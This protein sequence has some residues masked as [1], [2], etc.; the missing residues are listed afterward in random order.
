MPGSTRYPGTAEEYGIVLD[1]YNTVLNELFAGQEVYLITCDWSDGP[2]PGVRPDDHTR[3]HPGARYWTSVC[4]DP[5]ETDPDFISYTHLFVSRI[6]WQ[7]GALDEL[8]R[9]V[10]DD[11][12]AGVMITDLTMERI[13]HPYDGGADV[14]L[15]TTAERDELGHRY[16]DWLSPHPEGL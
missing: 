3:W 4:N 1:R 6:P 15:P 10:A 2:E 13:H 5:T 12:T 14:L 7:P 9:A 16:A 8:L 11:S